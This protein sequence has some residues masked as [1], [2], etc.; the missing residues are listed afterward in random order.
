MPATTSSPCAFARK[1]PYGRASPVAGSRVNATPVP[2]SSPL[3]PNTIVWT[4][5]A[6][7]RPAGRPANRRWALGRFPLP[8]WHT[9]PPPY[10]H[11]PPP[12]SLR[13]PPPSSFHT[14]LATL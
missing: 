6:V 5:T 4:F 13:P 3:L 8:L 2:E 14:P 7:P 11:F 12:Y 1:S 10:P 9:A